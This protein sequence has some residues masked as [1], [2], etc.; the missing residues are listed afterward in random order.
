[1]Q[2]IQISHHDFQYL[3]YPIATR[4]LSLMIRLGW[5]E[6]FYKYASSLDWL[7]TAAKASCLTISSSS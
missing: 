5:L 7:A 1:M 3:I 6:N 2:T 4:A